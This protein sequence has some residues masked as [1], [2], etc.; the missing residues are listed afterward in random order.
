MAAA[1]GQKFNFPVGRRLAESVGYDAGVL[2]RL[3]RGL[4]ESFTGAG[5]PQPFVDAQT[6]E[7]VLDLGCGAGLDLYLYAQKLV[8]NGQLFGLDL[9]QSMLD[10]ARANLAAVGVTNVACLHAPCSRCPESSGTSHSPWSP[11]SSGDCSGSAG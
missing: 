11:R 6:S 3:P 1:P 9:S 5:N 10:K 4:W 2:D 8:P 7:S